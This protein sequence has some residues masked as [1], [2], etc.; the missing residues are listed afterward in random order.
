MFQNFRYV[1]IHLKRLGRYMQNQ[2]FH[3][4]ECAGIVKA[5]FSVCFNS[6]IKYTAN[7]GWIQC[8]FTFTIT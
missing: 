2:F 6:N 1:G 5:S 4:L 3:T 7:T 8:I